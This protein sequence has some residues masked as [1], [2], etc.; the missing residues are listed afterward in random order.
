MAKGSKSLNKCYIVIAG[1]YRVDKYQNNVPGWIQSAGGR[2]QSQVDDNTTHVLA[3]EKAWKRKDG[4]VTKALKLNQEEG[5]DIKIVSFDW[6]EDCAN[7]RSKKKEGPYLWEKLNNSP[8]KRDNAHKRAEEA[9]ENEPR[10]HVGMMKQVFDESTEQ[11]VDEN[12]RKRVEREIEK[13]GE[14]RKAIEDDEKREREERKKKA[15]VFGR[16]AKKA[17]NEMFTENHHIYQDAT[18]FKYDVMLTKVG[19]RN[20]RNERYALTV[21]H[22]LRLLCYLSFNP[23]H[24][25][26]APDLRTQ[27]RTLHLR[28]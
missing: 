28:H 26:T 24:L 10:N 5:R 2:T 22:R 6:L 16:G 23:D 15:Q 11:F 3:S 7:N 20:N 9:K 19:T 8:Q 13:E 17:R 25:R 18:G 4:A 12:A 14:V 1:Q 27:C 21:S